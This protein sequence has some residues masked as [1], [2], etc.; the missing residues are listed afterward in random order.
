MPLFKLPLVEP[1]NS[2]QELPA[3]YTQKEVFVCK[4][5]F[6]TLKDD[7]SIKTVELP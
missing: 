4:K 3:E 1:I 6:E 2:T 5:V 7:F